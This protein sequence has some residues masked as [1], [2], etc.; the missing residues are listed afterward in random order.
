MTARFDAA[1]LDLSRLPSPEVVKNVD[2]EA[3]LAA[4]IA[5]L[6]AR[7]N[8]AG[9]SYD[10]DTLETDPAA[11]L[12]QEDAYREALDLAAINDAARSVLIAFATGAD[13]DNLA[14]F[15]GV[16]R[17][18]VTPATEQVAEVLEDDESLRT[19]VLLAPEALP[20]AGMTGGGYRSLALKIAPSVK[21]AKPIKRAGGMVDVVLLSRTGTG[22]VASGVV[23]AVY[24]AFQDDEATQLTDIVSVRSATILSYAVALTLRIP[25]GP[26][27][28]LIKATAKKAVEAYVLARHKV[29]ARVYAQM[30]EAVAS[31]GGVEQVASDL[32]DIVPAG[33]QAAYCTGV[34]VD[35]EI[36]S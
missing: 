2:Y 3:I 16:V 9:I 19:R 31:V 14:A 24:A 17:L 10:V 4:R 27:P 25:L 7:F 26:D 18:V 13:L 35:H 34:T 1:N 32:E 20:Y 21:D 30:I 5:D 15:Y 33:D 12:Q 6:K 11:I 36:I 23:S 8:A 29:G 28:A 22:A